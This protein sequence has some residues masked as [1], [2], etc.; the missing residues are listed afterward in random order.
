MGSRLAKKVFQYS[1]LM[2]KL[3]IMDEKQWGQLNENLKR[4]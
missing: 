2:K 3:G 1:L 4:K